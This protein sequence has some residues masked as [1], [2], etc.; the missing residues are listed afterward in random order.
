MER[1][2]PRRVP[3]DWDDLEMA[4]T[5]RMDEWECYLDLRTGAVHM[6]R[7]APFGDEDEGLSE[8]EVD[9]GLAQGHLIPIEPLPSSVEYGWM[10]EF[11]ESVAERRL[12]ELLEVALDGRG[13]FRRFKDVLLGYPA[14]RERWFAVRDRRLREAMLEWLADHEIEPT[15]RPPERK[16]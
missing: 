11:A 6:V 8:E 10:V 14:E 7:P 9:A 13:A 1:R 12:R 15:T 16:P 5:T 4:L 2:E 3:L